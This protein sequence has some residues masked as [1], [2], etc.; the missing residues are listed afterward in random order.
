M[1]YKNDYVAVVVIS[2]DNGYADRRL[3]IDGNGCNHIDFHK[4]LN[5]CVQIDEI[6]VTDK[7]AFVFLINAL[8]QFAKDNWCSYVFYDGCVDTSIFS[9]LDDYGFVE[10]GRDEYNVVLQYSVGKD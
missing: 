3:F 2:I 1:K 9:Y 8:I 4:C 7:V 10:I 6:E 5:G